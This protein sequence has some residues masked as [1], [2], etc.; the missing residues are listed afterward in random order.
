MS[1][2]A[3]IAGGGIAGLAAGAALACRGW[4][5]RIYERSP[6]LRTFGAGIYIWENGLRVL[7]SIGAYELAV[8]D[9]L[10]GWRRDARDAK[11]RVFRRNVVQGARLFTI[12]RRNL[13]IAL[14]DAAERAGC[15][16]E[17]GADVQAGA[18][19]GRLRIGDHWTEAADLVVAADGVNS[20]VR[21]SFDVIASRKWIDQY[22]IRVLIDRRPD[23][24]ATELG[25]SHCEYWS[26]P[27]RLLYAPCTAREAYVQLTS[28]YGDPRGNRIPMDSAYWHERFPHAGWIIDRVPE[29]G[30]GDRFQVLK[31]KRWSEGRIAFIG[32]AAHAQPP[33]L[34]QGGGS[35]LMNALSLAVTLE[36]AEPV[37]AALAKWEAA[38]RPL[39]EF[40]QNVAYRFGQ[41]CSLPDSLRAPILRGLDRSDWLKTRTIMALALH[42]PTGCS[43]PARGA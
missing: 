42:H 36:S 38:E 10:P 5:V 20:K 27:N 16:V 3:I 1:R 40:S 39:I 31:L 24:L 22:A 28:P 12:I 32:D 9:Q 25:R 15:E 26:G 17:F 6:E 33:N 14:L 8:R 2:R 29:G 43:S 7:E 11:N 23:E 35:A 30:R 37:P 18:A 21:D 4:R 13:L 41:L 19:D 34:G